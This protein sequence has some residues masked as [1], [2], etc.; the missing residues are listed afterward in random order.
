MNVL[1]VATF[2][3][4]IG[5]LSGLIRINKA[6]AP[7][8]FLKASDFEALAFLDDLHELAGLGQ[9]MERA[10]VEPSRSPVDF[11]QKLRLKSYL[12]ECLEV[13]PNLSNHLPLIFYV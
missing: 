7:G 9:G 12:L 8:D 3:E 13:K 4:F 10:G 2:D 6:H 1:A 11:A 5:Q